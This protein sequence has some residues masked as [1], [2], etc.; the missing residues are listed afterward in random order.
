MHG[1]LALN[2]ARAQPAIG[3]SKR[4]ARFR[5]CGL[6]S[7]SQSAAAA[8]AA[9]DGGTAGQPRSFQ[10]PLPLRDAGDLDEQPSCRS[11]VPPA[12]AYAPKNVL[13]RETCGA[14][15]GRRR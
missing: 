2:R 4:P 12:G 7:E 3:Y 6:E 14:A 10:Q 15:W 1:S 5:L 13:L 8:G 11:H 9:D